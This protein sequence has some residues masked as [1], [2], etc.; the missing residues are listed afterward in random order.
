MN[1]A[2]LLGTKKVDSDGEHIYNREW[3]N[4]IILDACRRDVF[5]EVVSSDVKKRVSLGSSTPD[6]IKRSFSE[7]DYGDTVYISA[8]PHFHRS[9]FVE[10]TGRRPEEVFHEVFHTY[11]TDWSEDKK[12]ILP[13]SVVRDALTTEKLFPD[14]R[15]IIHFMQPHYP[16]LECEIDS[17]GIRM[18]DGSRDGQTTIESVKQN[19]VWDLCQQGAVEPKAAIRG[20]KTNLDNVTDYVNTLAG[21]LSGRTV[22]TSDHGNLIGENGFYGHPS[23]RREQG[24]RYVPW[25]VVSQEK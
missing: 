15:K 20:Y 23:G 11:R 4:L 16:F 3:D 24:L 14:K 7:G 12:T 1:N 22:V 21:K 13:E 18:I 25:K 5:G 10:L 8:N 17:S 6:Y 2:A 9:K 19:N